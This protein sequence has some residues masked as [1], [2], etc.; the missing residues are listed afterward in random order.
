MCEGYTSV[1]CLLHP[2]A[3]D[4]ACNPG[5][6]RDWESNQRPFGLQAG[7]QSTEPHQPGI[8]VHFYYCYYAGIFIFVTQY[9][10]HI[11]ASLFHLINAPWVPFN[12][13][14]TSSVVMTTQHPLHGF[15]NWSCF[16]TQNKKLQST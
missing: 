13:N 1:S 9:H 16:E 2:P 3:G 12:T 6:C 15:K 5:M 10:A 8:I 14:S 11:S 7:T 4:A